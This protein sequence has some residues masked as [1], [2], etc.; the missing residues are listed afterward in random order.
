MAKANIT[1]PIQDNRAVD[2]SV[3]LLDELFQFMISRQS[4]TG[5]TSKPL[6]LLRLITSLCERVWVDI[7]IP[8]LKHLKGPINLTYIQKHCLG[9]EVET[10]CQTQVESPSQS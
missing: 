9:K 3:I 2:V 5:N 7:F 8:P 4:K 6:A 10:P 1:F